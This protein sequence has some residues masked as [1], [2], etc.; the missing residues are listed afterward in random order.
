M[1]LSLPSRARFVR[2]FSLTK[3][4]TLG[5]R[6]SHKFSDQSNTLVPCFARP[7]YTKNINMLR[8]PE[9]RERQKL[10]RER[11]AYFLTVTWSNLSSFWVNLTL[12]RW[13]TIASWSSPLTLVC[14]LYG[15][16]SMGKPW[17]SA[18]AQF[19]ISNVS[20]IPNMSVKITRNLLISTYSNQCCPEV[21]RRQTTLSEPR[22]GHGERWRGGHVLA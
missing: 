1:K 14:G 13:L 18:S 21:P 11:L 22:D 15:S 10:Q 5:N 2:Q 17:K 6:E 7:H 19:G 12:S 16:F 4:Q 9:Q 8:V 3:T 20:N